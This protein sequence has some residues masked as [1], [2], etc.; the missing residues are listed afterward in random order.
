MIIRGTSKLLKISRIKPIKNQWKSDQVLPGEWYGNVLK[1]GHVGK[2]YILFFHNTTKISIICP[3]KSINKAVKLLPERVKNLLI[4]HH[5]KSFLD[6]FELESE[7]K[8]YTTNDRSTLGFMNQPIF[9]A[10]WHLSKDRSLEKSKLEHIENILM[11]CMFPTKG[12]SN[13]Y[14]TPL[15]ILKNIQK[16][17]DE[18][19]K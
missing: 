10:E 1:T 4:R 17:L 7:N 5:F 13:N 6:K 14:E 2:T 15:D 12:D 16:T 19:S 9:T 3:T 11:T 8:I 18:T